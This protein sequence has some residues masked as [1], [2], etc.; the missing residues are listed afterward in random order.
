MSWY[1]HVLYYW[2]SDE[3][4][5]SCCMETFTDNDRSYSN[6]VCVEMCVLTNYGNIAPLE[7]QKENDNVALRKICFTRPNFNSSRLKL[8]TCPRNTVQYATQYVRRQALHRQK[9]RKPNTIQQDIHSDIRPSGNSPTE[10]LAGTYF[11]L[12]RRKSRIMARMTPI[13]QNG[14]PRASK[15][16]K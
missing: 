13:Q 5:V 3:T 9:K 7:G 6:F 4:R 1:P 2:P 15:I 16:L 12:Y 11:Y 10:Y 14:I 8:K